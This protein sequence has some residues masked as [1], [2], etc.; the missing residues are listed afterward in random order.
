MGKNTIALT[1]KFPKK[2]G[3]NYCTTS[4]FS[5]A[6]DSFSGWLTCEP[7]IVEVA[8]GIKHNSEPNKAIDTTV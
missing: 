3:R 6:Q 7:G 1:L 5:K 2:N 4:S 8:L